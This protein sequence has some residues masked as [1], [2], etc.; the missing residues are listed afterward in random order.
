[1]ALP[2]KGWLVSLSNEP[3]GPLTGADALMRL[4]AERH[5]CLTFLLRAIRGQQPGLTLQF[6]ASTTAGRALTLCWVMPSAGAPQAVIAALLGRPTGPKP[7]RPPRRR[8]GVA[9][10]DTKPKRRG[11][12]AENIKVDWAV[13]AEP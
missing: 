12:G 9:A 7:G 11:A 6:L 2:T 4:R 1:M 8:G 10:V 13:R 5:P 3:Q